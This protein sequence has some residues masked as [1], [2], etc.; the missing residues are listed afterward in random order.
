MDSIKIF[1][2]YMAIYFVFRTMFEKLLQFYMSFTR[3][4]IFHKLYKIKDPSPHYSWILIKNFV[5]QYI[6]RVFHPFIL[7]LSPKLFISFKRWYP[8]RVTY[9]RACNHQYI[10]FPYNFFSSHGSTHSFNLVRVGER[11][12]AATVKCKVNL[13]FH[14]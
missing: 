3:L 12:V 13:L 9:P 6:L 8:T 5:C 11:V 7:F 4:G 14:C 1:C 10:L 2:Y